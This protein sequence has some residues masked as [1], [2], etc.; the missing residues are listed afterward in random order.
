MNPLVIQRLVLQCQQMSIKSVK[1]KGTSG[2]RKYSSTLSL[3]NIP[4][5]VFVGETIHHAAN[6]AEVTYPGLSLQ[7]SVGP[8]TGGYT[9]SLTHPEE[10]TSFFILLT[11]DISDTDKIPGIC[12]HESLH[13]SWFI[14][15]ALGIKNKWNNHEPQAYILQEIFDNCMK[16]YTDFTNRQN[17]KNS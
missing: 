7:E 9:A 17:K 15:N 10:G 11:P 16:A 5:D 14:S 3:Y 13:L 4:Y 1:V 2:A 6:A 8:Q 12:A